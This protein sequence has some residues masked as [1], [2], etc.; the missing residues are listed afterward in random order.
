VIK[1]L[2]HREKGGY[3]RVSV[4][5]YYRDGETVIKDVTIY[6]ANHKN[7]LYSPHEGDS[8]MVVLSTIIFN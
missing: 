7:P 6:I 1:N 4:N 3:D 2:D 5:F 8:L